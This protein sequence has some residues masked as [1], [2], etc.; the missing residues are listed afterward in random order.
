MRSGLNSVHVG[1]WLSGQGK[2]ADIVISSR[3]RLAR[4]VAGIPFLARAGM[5]EQKELLNHANVALGE[6]FAAD[7]R[8]VVMMDEISPLEAQFLLERHLISPHFVQ[9]SAARGFYVNPDE[10]LS[11]MV[12][13]EDH[14]RLQTLG[15]GLCL[16]ELLSRISEVDSGLN[17]RLPYA[18]DE[19]YG[20]LT[21]CPTNVGTG[22]RTSILIHLPGVVVT[23]EID[24]VLRGVM[25]LGLS[26][27]G[28]YGEGTETRG[29]L[30]QISNQRTLGQSEEE[31]VDTLTHMAKQIIRYERDAREYLFSKMSVH[32]NDKVYRSLGILKYARVLSSDE[33][34]NLLSTL[35]LGIPQLKGVN[36]ADLNRLMIITQPANLQ[37]YFGKDLEPEARDRKRAQMIRE[38]FGHV[39]A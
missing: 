7:G 14:L 39:Q 31:I 16:K 13:E 17:S 22:M 38:A 10:T 27:R 37:V 18:Y 26:V 30:F 5:E 2:D 36:T 25:Q 24:R 32:M 35:R 15:S 12:N 20:F 3:I 19:R 21:A 6:L 28:T 9:S 4:N 23:K 33:V 29:Y 8:G 34:I 1:Q 11:L